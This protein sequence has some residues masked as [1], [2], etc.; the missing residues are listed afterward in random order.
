MIEHP[1]NTFTVKFDTMLINLE[2]FCRVSNR[3]LLTHFNVLVIKMKS[4]LWIQRVSNTE[5]LSSNQ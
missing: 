3:I 2:K 5:Y 4:A 1:S